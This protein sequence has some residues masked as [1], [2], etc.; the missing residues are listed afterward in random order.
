MYSNRHVFRSLT[1]V[2][3][4]TTLTLAV[5]VPFA[6]AGSP[7]QPPS[8]AVMA[9]DR[10]AI[11]RVINA[12]S[13]ADRKVALATVPRVFVGATVSTTI[14]SNS[15]T[16]MPNSIPA[17]SVSTT[18]PGPALLIKGSDRLEVSGARRLGDFWAITNAL[19]PSGALTSATFTAF[20]GTAIVSNSVVSPSLTLTNTTIAEVLAV[21]IKTSNPGAFTLTLT[22]GD[23]F[24][25]KTAEVF[26]APEVA[27]P[28]GV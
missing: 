4:T 22:F 10:T 1:L 8:R 18:V 2:G 13:P 28:L 7:T 26:F 21:Q 16:T 25:T 12:G 9:V 5:A 24:A 6:V 11:A 17:P 27:P 15:T 19:S 3:L 23:R 14:P 20:G